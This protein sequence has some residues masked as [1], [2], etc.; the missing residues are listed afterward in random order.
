MRWIGIGLST[1][2]FIIEKGSCASERSSSDRPN[3]LEYSLGYSNECV[4]A[5]VELLIDLRD[6]AGKA[7]EERM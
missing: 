1:V 2:P 3:I 4:N 7:K 5:S 6:A